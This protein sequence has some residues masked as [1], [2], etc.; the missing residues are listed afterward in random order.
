VTLRVPA[1]AVDAPLRQSLLR[2][3]GLATFVTLLGIGLAAGAARQI[4][5]PIVALSKA[6]PQIA[7]GDEPLTVPR[8][9]VTE[10]DEVGRAMQ[11]AYRE[12]Q[13]IEQQNRRLFAETERRRH[14]AESLAE[15]SWLM[16]RSLDSEGVAQ[17]IVN[18][19]S[20]LLAANVAVLY[21]LEPDS[22]DLVLMA[23]LA[24]DVQL[25]ARMSWGTPP[26]WVWP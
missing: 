16:S 13:R 7:S 20:R 6:A 12:R 25:P 10:V 11:A 1:G 21:R 22:E 15:V 8:S 3:G 19:V 14:S 24:H 18:S 23:S 5:R 26:W 2:L 9:S 17:A 4:R